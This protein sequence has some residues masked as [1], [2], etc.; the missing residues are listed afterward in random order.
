MNAQYVHN[1]VFELTSPRIQSILWSMWDVSISAMCVSYKCHP[2]EIIFRSHP[3]PNNTGYA[4][5]RWLGA[6]DLISSPISLV[7]AGGA[8]PSPKSTA[9]NSFPDS[10]AIRSRWSRLII[11]WDIRTKDSRIV[12]QS[13]ARV[14]VDVLRDWWG[15]ICI[16]TAKEHTLRCCVMYRLKLLTILV[17]L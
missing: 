12:F 17:V 4:R 6:N 16:N 3:K 9:A 10:Q 2:L 15:Q 13:Y 1:W 7:Q 11:R 14:S 5:N 8:G